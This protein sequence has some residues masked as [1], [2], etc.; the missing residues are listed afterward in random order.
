MPVRLPD[1]ARASI[2]LIVS[3]ASR[4]TRC[5][6]NGFSG[7]SRSVP[8][9]SSAKSSRILASIARSDGRSNSRAGSTRPGRSALDTAWPARQRRPVG[10]V[11]IAGPRSC[12]N[13][14]GSADP[15]FEHAALRPGVVAQR[16]VEAA[17]A[18][19]AV[20]DLDIPDLACLVERAID[21]E[22]GRG[23]QAS[24]R[25]RRRPLRANG[26]ASM[27]LPFKAC[28]AGT[29]RTVPSKSNLA[30]PTLPSI[31]SGIVPS[32]AQPRAP[33]DRASILIG[34]AR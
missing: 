15:A 19:P 34:K 5:A 13:R 29:P 24:R 7:S 22:C 20:I 18:D 6:R 26:P 11:P 30:Y 4:S 10:V 16:R 12:S 33:D 31:L 9:S 23:R 3:T 32:P 17:V 27:K 1:A 14:R 28:N 21:R 25:S 8:R 2:S